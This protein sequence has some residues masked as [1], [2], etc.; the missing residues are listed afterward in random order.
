MLVESLLSD[1]ADVIRRS[2]VS[3]NASASRRN[4]DDGAEWLL[5]VGLRLDE[6]V[7]H[8]ISAFK[9][10]L[11]HR[12]LV[13]RHMISKT[14][15][16]NSSPPLIWRS[17]AN[18]LVVL[19]ISSIVDQNIRGPSK[20]FLHGSEELLYL[21][22]RSDIG[23]DGQDLGRWIDCLELGGNFLEGI[24]SSCSDHNSSCSC[25]SPYSCSSLKTSVRDFDGENG[26]LTA[27]SP[28]LA[29]VI[30]M[31]FPFWEFEGFEGSI[32][33]YG[34]RRLVGVGMKGVVNWSGSTC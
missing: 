8:D 27:P 29:P 22:F 33:G 6:V 16:Y 9:V 12:L 20:C 24:Q 15:T 31:I 32:A 25:P 5:G 11:L 3:G 10:D 21:I 2:S 17:L 26:D 28:P 34:S 13:S 14:M 7:C 1:L 18:K 4:R 23:L 30:M 19:E